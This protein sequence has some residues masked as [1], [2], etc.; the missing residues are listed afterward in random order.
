MKKY[1]SDGG[2]PLNVP[3]E[4]W[5]QL[6]MASLRSGLTLEPWEIGAK[7]V[8][9][10]LARNSPESLS[11]P[12]TTGYQWKQLFLPKGTLLRTVF[13][14]KH[15][16]CVVEEG[17]L[18][19]NG[20]ATSPSGFANA[21]GGVRRNAWRVI[22]VLFPDTSEWKLADSLRTKRSD[23]RR[24]A[25]QPCEEPH[26]R[27]VPRD[28]G[29][30]PEERHARQAE[31]SPAG[32]PLQA[33]AASQ[34]GDSLGQSG[35]EPR[36]APADRRVAHGERRRQPAAARPVPPARGEAVPARPSAAPHGARV[37]P[38]AGPYAT[39]P[40]RLPITWRTPL[41]M[42]ERSRKSERHPQVPFAWAD[43]RPYT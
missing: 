32:R 14:G 35:R 23:A 16:H 36:R 27:Q 17:G 38:N 1:P 2:V 4:T 5:Q 42:V 43:R 34:R 21:V 18:R 12:C 9:D 11:L 41:G 19:Y 24:P 29:P 25:R 33:Q 26:A 28:A 7:A 20:E 10:Y 15:Y 40:A 13:N 30:M 37:E 3:L 22:W 39:R 31:P 8:H 6:N